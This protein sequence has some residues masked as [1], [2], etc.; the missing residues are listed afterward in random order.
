MLPR[1]I[2]SKPNCIKYHINQ[3]KCSSKFQQK[4]M[5]SKSN[6]NHSTTI[7]STQSSPHHKPNQYPHKSSPNHK[8]M[9]IN[10]KHFF[11]SAQ[12]IQG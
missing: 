7:P 11:L 2:S 10:T 9:T 3:T 6:P 12:L 4:L 8:S 1:Q 5:V